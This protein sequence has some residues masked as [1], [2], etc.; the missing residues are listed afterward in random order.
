MY[1]FT[2][3]LAAVRRGCGPVLAA[4]LALLACA[5]AID[6][7]AAQTGAERSAAISVAATLPVETRARSLTR[8]ASVPGP[9][10]SADAQAVQPQPDP[11]QQGTPEPEE[12]PAQPVFRTGINFVRVDVIATDRQGNPV[13]DLTSQD[14]EVFEDDKPQSIES[15]KLVELT[16]RP[17]GSEPARAIRTTYDEESEAQREDVRIFVFLLDDY[18]VRL[19]ASLAARRVL[20]DFIRNELGPLDLIGVMYPLTPVS[21]LLLTRDH[22]SVVRTIEGFEGRKGDYLPRN[23]FEEKYATYPTDVVERIRNQVSLSAVEGLAVRLGGVRE[24]RKAI[25]L[26]SEGFSN[27][28]PPQLRDPIASMPGLGNPNR[29]NPNAGRTMAEEREQ[30]F[31]N[32]DLNVDM[33]DVFRAANRGNTAIYALDPRGLAAFEYDVTENIGLETDLNMLNATMNTLRTLADETDGRAIVNRGDLQ[34]GLKQIVRDSSVYYLIGYNSTQAPADGK[35]HEIKVRVKRSGVQVRAR[36]GYW[37]LTPEETARALAPPR[38]GPDPAISNALAAVEVPSRAR[39]VRTWVGMVGGVEGKTRVTLV[40]EPVPPVPGDDRRTPPAR[41]SVVAAGEGPAYF[42]GKVPEGGPAGGS[43][44][45]ER[46][47]R[48]VFDAD[49]GTLQVRLAVEDAGGRVID[50]DMLDLRVPDFTAPE[51]A[52]STPEVHRIRNA[53]ELRALNADPEPVP[54]AGREF[55]RTER[56]IVRFHTTAPGTAPTASEARLLNRSGQP[57]TTLPVQPVPNAAAQSQVDLPLAGLPPG[58][59]VL[60][61]TATS[62]EGSAKQHL[63]FRVIS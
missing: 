15:F 52:I 22:E 40:W 16:G 30:F 63:G 45:A 37:A 12:A 33:Q 59:Y 31:S 17:E 10:A 61:I 7:M 6:E 44:A 43:A 11:P 20:V 14:F 1:V 9:A 41:V 62:G 55:R 5:A 3:A 13:T 50:T 47:G 18:H 27:Y 48:V 60:E 57:M 26:V 21:G 46:G 28:V 51:L 19:A 29:R 2:Q 56:L 58:E 42:R 36:K 49:P 38:P 23:E 8:A 53:L 54:V 39:L 35:F 32:S 25:I 24:G 34:G 4:A